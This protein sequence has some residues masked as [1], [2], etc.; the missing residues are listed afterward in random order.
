MLVLRLESS[1]VVSVVEL[2]WLVRVVVVVVSVCAAHPTKMKRRII[3]IVPD[4][5]F[6]L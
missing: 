1:V 6:W 5:M 2:R 3:P 4:F